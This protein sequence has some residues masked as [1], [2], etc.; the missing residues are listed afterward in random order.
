[1]PAS[2]AITLQQPALRLLTAR[3]VVRSLNRFRLPRYSYLAWW[4]EDL[5]R[6]HYIVDLWSGV[7]QEAPPAGCSTWDLEIELVQR[8]HLELFPVDLEVMDMY[9][10]SG[11]DPFNA[12]IPIAGSGI[13]WEFEILDCLP[14]YAQPMVA[15]L[16]ATGEIE[17]D[18]LSDNLEGWWNDRNYREIP[19]LRWPGDALERLQQL[20]NE[21]NGLATLYHCITKD[22]GNEFIDTSTD[23]AM[24]YILDFEFWTVEG[25][26]ILASEFAEVRDQYYRLQVYIQWFEHILGSESRVLSILLDLCEEPTDDNS[27]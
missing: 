8:V 18:E 24:E 11:E 22:T 17:S 1:M 25:I 5:G 3:D 20:P 23:W 2:T 4:L 19:R 10:N 16:N 21:L 9:V 14:D 27:D 7:F 6:S 26:Q 15:I 12:L 13:A